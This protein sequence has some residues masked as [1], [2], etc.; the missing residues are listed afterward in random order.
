MTHDLYNILSVS[1]CIVAL[2]SLFVLSSDSRKRRIA[3]LE[4]LIGGPRLG[5]EIPLRLGVRYVVLVR[6][7]ADG[8]VESEP[9]LPDY[10][11]ETLTGRIYRITDHGRRVLGDHDR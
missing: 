6:M 1:C 5:R 4:A 8:L 3:V 9:E 11:N 7:E 10:G 2:A